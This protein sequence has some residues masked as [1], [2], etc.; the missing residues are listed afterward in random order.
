MV[1]EACACCDELREP[2]SF[3]VKARLFLKARLFR[4]V[5]PN[6]LLQ[7]PSTPTCRIPILSKIQPKFKLASELSKNVLGTEHVRRVLKT[8][9]LDFYHAHHLVHH[10]GVI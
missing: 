7:T 8:R 2:C 6:D 10:D 3:S 1:L 5:R 9:G 4:R